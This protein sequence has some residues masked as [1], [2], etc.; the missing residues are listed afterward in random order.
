MTHTNDD[1]AMA[2]L[3]ALSAK[4]RSQDQILSRSGIAEITATREVVDRREAVPV[5][6]RYRDARNVKSEWTVQKNRPDWWKGDGPDGYVLEP[7]YAHPPQ[8]SETVTEAVDALV[9]AKRL[10]VGG[11]WGGES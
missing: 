11:G 3:A 8:P 7:L 4:L 2:R 5:A 9:Q 10:F 6:W 1:E